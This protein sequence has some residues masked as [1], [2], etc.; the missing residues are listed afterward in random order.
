M[1]LEEDPSR[2]EAAVVVV[3]IEAMVEKDTLVDDNDDT[4]VDGDVALRGVVV[5]G[6]SGDGVGVDCDRGCRQRGQ[7]Q[8]LVKVEV[9]EED[10]C[11]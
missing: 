8:I 4:A 11:R 9:V 6:G 2:M 7:S 10:R 1:N 5:V 3:G